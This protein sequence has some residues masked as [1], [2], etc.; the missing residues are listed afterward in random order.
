M[1]SMAEG[2]HAVVRVRDNGHGI[3]T[4]NLERIFESFARVVPPAGDPGGMGLGLALVANLVQLHQGTVVARS[5][6]PGRGS[7]FE[8]RLPLLSDDGSA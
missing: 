2:A 4:E 8:V 3:A 5:E 1:T 7:E 6:G